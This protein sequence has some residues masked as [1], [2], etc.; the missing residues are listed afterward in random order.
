MKR[1]GSEV[2][3]IVL[4]PVE[5]TAVDPISALRRLG[6][7][8]RVEVLHSAAACRARCRDKSVDL[9][10]AESALGA[11][12]WELLEH[13][14]AVGPP[15]VVIND[16]GSEYAALE[17]FKRGAADCVVAGAEFADVLPV[18]A[19]EQIQRWRAAR[20]QGVAE[21]RIRDLESYNQNIIQ[22]LNSALL[23]V[24]LSGQIVFSNPPAEEILGESAEALRGRPIWP[25]FAGVPQSEIHV[26]RTLETGERFKGLESTLTR[27]DGTAVPIGI[28]S[29]PVIDGAGNKL[30]AVAVFSDLTE[31]KLLQR[32]VLQTEKMASIGQLAAG[33]AHEINNPMGFIHANLFQMAEYMTDL[34]RVWDGV[35]ALQAAVAGGDLGEIRRSSDELTAISEQINIAFVL[36]DFAKAIRESQEGSERIRHIVN[37]L[38][39]FSHRDSEHPALADVNQ[40]LDSTASIVWPMMKHLV[41]LEKEYRD[42]PKVHC[43]PMQLQQVFMNLMVNAYQAIEQKVGDSGEAGTIWLRT[44]PR[45]G[46][47]AIS[48]K[49]TGVGIAPENLD[50]IFDPFFTTKKVGMGTGLGLST[51]FNIVERHGGSLVAESEP[52]VETVFTVWLP[53]AN[54][55]GAAD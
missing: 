53:C 40:F 55:D 21:R 9:I 33:V 11:E 23:V 1:V 38:R 14:S 34:H 19:L 12:C 4:R 3:I 52:G 47:V 36:S 29:A 31:I 5:S 46:G 24:D 8:A 39:D 17:A 54:P 32:K 37:D 30:G 15:V 28:S 2:Q 27:V 6:P 42:L 20:D 10:V 26:A 45:E 22:N 50:R 41:V 35:G 18:V 51:C 7:E 48:V 44:E 43:Y 49:D 16:D 13:S 25:W